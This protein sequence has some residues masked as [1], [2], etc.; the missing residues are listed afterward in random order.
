MHS[1]KSDT[2]SIQFLG[3]KLYEILFDE[4]K[5]FESKT[6]EANYVHVGYVKLAF[7]DFYLV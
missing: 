3:P 5:Q 2:E 7:I 6:L 1:V 4:I